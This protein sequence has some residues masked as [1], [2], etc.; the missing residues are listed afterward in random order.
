MRRHLVVGS[1]RPRRT[2]SRVAMYGGTFAAGPRVEGGW[3]VSAVL[4]L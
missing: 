3:G 1:V 4:P 2:Y